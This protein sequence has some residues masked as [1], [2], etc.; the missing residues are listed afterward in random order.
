LSRTSQIR[1][2]LYLDF[3]KA[4]SIW[5]QFDEGLLERVTV[6]EDVGKDRVAGT[7][8]G[9]PG[10]A[11]AN[12]GVDYLQKKS[13]LKSRTLHHDLLNRV[14][15]RLQGG[16]LVSDLSEMDH[17]VAS[18]AEIR[19][20]IGERPYLRA[21]GSSVIEDYRRILAISE[22]FNDILNFLTKAAQE[23]ARKT[24]AF[25]EL[26][27]LIDAAEASAEQEKDRNQRAIKKS[28]AKQMRQK[29]EELLHP[30]FGGVDEWLIDG[31]RLF[32]NTFM[33]SRINFRIYPFPQCPSFQV[34]CNLKRDCFVDSDLE[35]LLYGY[36][37]RPNVPLSVFG[38]ITSLPPEVPTSFDPLAEFQADPALAQTAAFEQ[39]FRGVFAGMEGFEAQV[40][41]ARFPNVTVHPIAVYRSF[42]VGT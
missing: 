29:A 6:N 37:S 34:L 35:H 42:E 26:Q 33:A 8:F 24:P 22:K 17:L 40:R 39:G 15:A 12:L 25:L 16:G 3:D 38:L 7:K 2:L 1:D 10:L 27:Q 36:G 41:F 28:Q 30:Q 31:M 19:A 13:T 14:E 23:T 21:E 4:A 9:I 20:A 11:E 18:A 32:I 5:S